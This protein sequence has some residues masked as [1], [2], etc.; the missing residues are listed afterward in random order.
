MAIIIFESRTTHS[1]HASLRRDP[2]VRRTVAGLWGGA[3]KS[4]LTANAL[5][6]YNNN[7]SN[8]MYA[9]ARF[10]RFTPFSVSLVW[11][12]CGAQHREI[13]VTRRIRTC[14]LLRKNA[15]SLF[16]RVY[17]LYIYISLLYNARCITLYVII[18]CS[19]H[20]C[21]GRSPRHFNRPGGHRSCRPAVRFS[22]AVLHS[23]HDR[24]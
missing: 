21:G 14:P 5:R 6:W 7:N 10:Q 15:I 11:C 16:S 12:S 24:L 13:R 19:W 20:G 1:V 3:G 22:D 23:Y 2:N 17:K 4:D 8:N 18:Q 9:C